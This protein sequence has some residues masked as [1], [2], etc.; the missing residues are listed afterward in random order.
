MILK[1]RDGTVIEY[2]KHYGHY[3]IH[4]LHRPNRNGRIISGKQMQ[5][6]CNKE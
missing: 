5:I 1:L 6:V 4:V 3:W 2:T